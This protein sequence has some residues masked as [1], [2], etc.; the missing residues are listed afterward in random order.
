VP[1]LGRVAVDGAPVVLDDEQRAAADA[2]VRTW[3]RRHVALDSGRSSTWATG[4]GVA[5][6]VAALTGAEPGGWP[7]S[8]VLDGEYGITGAAVTV[9][10]A[11]GPGVGVVQEWALTP[12]EHAAL[13]DAAA[14]V[15]AA[16]A[17][18]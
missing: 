11:L 4:H 1:L 12:A 15:A 6:M 13:R 14:G 5:R 16:A 2:F 7:A 8:V 18:L 10:V 9:P 17:G 3:Y